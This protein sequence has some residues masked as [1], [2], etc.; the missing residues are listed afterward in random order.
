M[1]NKSHEGLNW[2]PT[3]H[4]SPRYQD[5]PDHRAVSGCF[6][7]AIE[8]GSPEHTHVV[9]DA[10]LQ[11]KRHHLEDLPEGGA[12]VT[13]THART[14]AH[15]HTH[16]QPCTVLSSRDK[17][18]AEPSAG[19]AFQFKASSS[20]CGPDLERM[21]QVSHGQL[22]PFRSCDQCMLQQAFQIGSTT[23]QEVGVVF[24]GGTDRGP[25]EEGVVESEEVVVE[26]VHRCV[27][28]E[29]VAHH[30]ESPGE[31]GGREG[32]REGGREGGREGD[33]MHWSTDMITSVSMY[34]PLKCGLVVTM[35]TPPL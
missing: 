1:V 4:W 18:E 17:L 27:G 6:T 15:T 24:K 8:G 5:C 29:T 9:G 26:V 22:L 34:T 21:Q 7:A 13:H 31:S 12:H 30:A 28:Q 2:W 25:G 19:V 20:Q 16:T 33:W 35:Y 10:Q 14:H 11:Q 23:T 3:C 32:E